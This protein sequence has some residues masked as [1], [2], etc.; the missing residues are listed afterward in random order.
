MVLELSKAN[1]GALDRAIGKCGPRDQIRRPKVEIRTKKGA[2]TDGIQP[3]PSGPLIRVSD[4]GFPSALLWIDCLGRT[5]SVSLPRLSA[6][7]KRHGSAPED[8]CLT[9]GLCCNGVIFADVK[10]Q[11]EEDAAPLLALGLPLRRARSAPVPLS[12]VS[13]K[14]ESWRFLQPCAAYDGCQCRIYS[15]RPSYCREFDCLLLKKVQRGRATHAEALR[16]VR[17]AR[18]QTEIV[19]KLL[20]ALGDMDE[21]DALA[22]RFRRTAKRLEQTEIGKSAANLFSQLT[23]AFHDLNFLLNEGFYPAPAKQ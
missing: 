10:L 9:C 12:T 5:S 17:T 22:E 6:Q 15:C 23:L 21:T 8:I 19:K 16:V 7:K 11:T 20:R 2:A 4:L 13:P 3:R 18:R 14:T 1:A